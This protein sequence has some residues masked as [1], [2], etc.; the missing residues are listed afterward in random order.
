MSLSSLLFAALLSQASVAPVSEAGLVHLEISK[1]GKTLQT[2]EQPFLMTQAVT[3]SAQKPFT[4]RQAFCAQQQGEQASSGGV[5]RSGS[6][7][8]FTPRV[9]TASG[10]VTAEVKLENSELVS[11]LPTQAGPCTGETSA[12]LKSDARAVFDFAPGVPQRLLVGEY[13]VTVTVTRLPLP[14]PAAGALVL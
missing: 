2:S 1:A 12:M 6:E 10:R 13:A 4:V 9:L 11:L 3:V 14:S 7:A 8:T 5:G